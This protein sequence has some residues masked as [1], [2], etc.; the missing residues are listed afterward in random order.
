MHENG[1]GLRDIRIILGNCSVCVALRALV[2]KAAPHLGAGNRHDNIRQFQF[3]PW[4]I[5]GQEQTS[6][7]SVSVIRV[8]YRPGYPVADQDT[9]GPIQVTASERVS[10]DWCQREI[11]SSRNDDQSHFKGHR[12]WKIGG[13][14]REFACSARHQHLCG[15]PGF[16]NPRSVQDDA[17]GRRIRL[18]LK[19]KT[20]LGACGRV[21]AGLLC[22]RGEIDQTQ[23]KV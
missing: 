17:R 6:T 3:D 10:L 15:E 11:S 21:I 4:G 19:A 5:N 22:L 7:T 9:N 16:R 12:A 2:S 20:Y 8:G 23:I 14:G 18:S 13:F 1:S